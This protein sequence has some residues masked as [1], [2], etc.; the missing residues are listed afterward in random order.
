MPDG[1]RRP[2]TGALRTGCAIVPKG[3]RGR[4]LRVV[5]DV[6]ERAGLVWVKSPANGDLYWLDAADVERH[7]RRDETAEGRLARGEI[8]LPPHRN[9]RTRAPMP[10]MVRS[11]PGM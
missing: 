5:A 9:L 8:E 7:W 11:G 3:G 10:R 6:D 1:E 2:T 4:T